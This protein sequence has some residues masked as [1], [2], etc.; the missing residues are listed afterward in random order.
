MAIWQVDKR[1]TGTQTWPKSCCRV[2]KLLKQVG[3]IKNQ[4]WVGF[5]LGLPHMQLV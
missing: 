5:N 2:R 3:N 1:P 4:G